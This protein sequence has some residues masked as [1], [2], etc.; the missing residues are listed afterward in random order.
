MKSVWLVLGLAVAA[1][2]ASLR[3]GS[4]T[5]TITRIG[6]MITANGT[7]T[8]VASVM[9]KVADHVSVALTSHHPPRQAS[10]SKKHTQP[11]SGIAVVA[12]GLA[13]LVLAAVG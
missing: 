13:G 3:L 8:V 10:Q 11:V 5:G 1:Q 2:G 12:F 9:D 7:S 4:D 6:G